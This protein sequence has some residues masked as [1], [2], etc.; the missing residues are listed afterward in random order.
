MKTD[1]CESL[2][3]Y[4]R[5]QTQEV[6]IGGVPLGNFLPVRL[7]SMTNTDT[8]DVNLTV[9]QVKRIVGE[10]ADYVR[11]TVPNKRALENLAEV[12]AELRRAGVHVPLIADIHYNPELAILAAQVVDK[13]RINPG[14]YGF[15]RNRGGKA[16]DPAAF[17]AEPEKLKVQLTELLEVCRKHNTAIRIG[18]NHGSLSARIL[19]KYGDTPEGMAES[20][21]EFLRICRE[22]NFEKVV[23]SMKA[24]NTR[25]MVYATRLLVSKMKQENMFFPVHLGVTEAGEGEDGRIRSAA[26]IGSLLS[27]GIGD[28]IRVSLTEDPEREIPVAKKIVDYITRR[29]DH[30]TVED[31]GNYPLDPC[32]YNKKNSD[33]VGKTGGKNPPVVVH[34]LHEGASLEKLK[35]IGWMYT[36]DS[37]W[38]FHDLAPDYL[39]TRDW[40]ASVPL[41][42]EKKIILPFDDS[43]SPGQGCFLLT[44][45]EYLDRGKEIKAVKFVQADASDL[46]FE[47]IDRLRGDTNI[48]LVI[49]SRN[50]NSAADQRAA[51]FRLMNRG[52][53]VPVIFRKCYHESGKEELQVK[54]ALDLG[55]L[56]IDGLGDG[57]WLENQGDLR[58]GDIVSASFGILQATWVRISKTEFISCPSCGRT[59]F[60][61][62]STTKKIRE[63]TSHLKGLK[64]G[65]MGCIV[66]GPGEMADADY[67]YVGGAKGKITLY[68]E[69]EVIRKNVP[70]EDAVNELIGLIKENGDWVDP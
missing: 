2:I 45:D 23:V 16:I 69:K 40:P 26:G 57:I 55:T 58:D 15:Q 39:F 18:T 46:R 5:R 42:D 49:D 8:N 65:I 3:R 47:V 56:F 27:D 4:N 28:T 59:L 51:V 48:I 21:M 9:Q 41:P 33:Q 25:V 37:G 34:V 62:Q 50:R 30:E 35:D 7:Q 6:D 43:M 20:A 44:L 22:S 54:S 11:V 53:P 19:N 61:L 66:N 52:C 13:V 60:D 10:G 12:K 70:E 17:D 14:N 24:S 68:K 67:G 29:A 63:R 32:H 31:F 38:E 1:Y 36:P 64:I